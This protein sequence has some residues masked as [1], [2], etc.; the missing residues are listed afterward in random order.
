MIKL[1]LEEKHSFIDCLLPRCYTGG[2]LSDIKS[3][4]VEVTWYAPIGDYSLG[5]ET[6]KHKR[7]EEGGVMSDEDYK[8][9]V[10]FKS[11]IATA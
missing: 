2:S 9:E 4:N 8:R 10:G 1:V 7:G 5:L 3:K 6:W 11:G